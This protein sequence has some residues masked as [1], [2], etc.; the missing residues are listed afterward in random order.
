MLILTKWLTAMVLP[1][2]NSLMLWLAA[3]LFK[4]CGW[5]KLSQVC[6]VAGVLLLYVFSTPFVAKKLTES[7]SVS[8][9]YQLADYRQAQAIVI[10]GGGVR[11]SHELF[12]DNAIAAT[13][14]ERMR[15]G[16][17]LHQQTALPILVTGGSP[18]K[19][20]PEADVMA[21]ELERFFQTP[22]KWIEN[23]SN[24]TA[25]NA[26]YSAAILN[27]EQIKKIVLVT[28]EWHLKRAKWLFEQQGFEVMT[29]GIGSHYAI[30]YGGMAFIPQAHALN[31]SSF[32][33][34]EWLGYWVARLTNWQTPPNR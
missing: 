13:P 26:Q 9:D 11:P 21:A 6:M 10:L 22:V 14:L 17:Y 32:V 15:Y 3:W 33:L 19:R 29:A 31:T 12:A 7:I 24:T 34:K 4:R 25:E 23:R 5:R 27:A 16:A 20:Q 28:N 1:P 30:E 2:F 18:E 8:A